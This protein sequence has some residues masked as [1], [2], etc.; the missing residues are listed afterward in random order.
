M[1]FFLQLRT[2][3]IQ[4]PLCCIIFNIVLEVGLKVPRSSRL[5]VTFSMSL[6]EACPKELRASQM[7]HCTVNFYIIQATLYFKGK[8]PV[9]LVNPSLYIVVSLSFL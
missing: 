7:A 4:P 6:C 8:T 5:E 3:D 9:A 2:Y 1:V